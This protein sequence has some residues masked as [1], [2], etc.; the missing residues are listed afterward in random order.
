[1]FLQENLCMG[2]AF[3][4]DTGLEILKRLQI[5]FY[6]KRDTPGKTED[7]QKEAIYRAKDS[8]LSNNDI[9]YYLG[10]SRDVVQDTLKKMG[11]QELKK[12]RSS[13]HLIFHEVFTS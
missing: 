7:H 9:A 13:R 6:N 8:Q 5:D 1:V 2:C 3:Q 4:K 12:E 11:S 10:V